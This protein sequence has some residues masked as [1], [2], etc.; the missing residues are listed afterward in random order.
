MNNFTFGVEIVKTDKETKN[1]RF[2]D[3]KREPLVDETSLKNR[4]WLSHRF[5]HQTA[6]ISFGANHLETFETSSCDHTA[7]MRRVLPCDS[8]FNL[9]LVVSMVRIAVVY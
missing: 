9:T 3:R 8:P 1:I 6:M 4:Q 2:R 7:P 5:V